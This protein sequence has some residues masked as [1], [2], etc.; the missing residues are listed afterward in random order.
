MDI[1][2]DASTLISFSQSCLIEILHRLQKQSNWRFLVT[3]TVYNEIITNPMKIKRFELNAIRLSR[4]IDQGWLAFIEPTSAETA[5]TEEISRHANQT[6]FANKQPLSLVHAGEAEALALC[7]SR[8]IPILAM[9]ERTTRM[10]IEGP[11]Q[12]RE[13]LAERTNNQIETNETSL[14][15]FRRNFSDLTIVRSVEL[16]GLAYERKLF[17]PTLS[18]NHQSLEAGLFALK[19]SGCAVSETELNEFLQ[20]HL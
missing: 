11:N 9:D 8:K 10:L 4:A 18:Q 3:R 20:K 7:Q 19:F 2:F 6:F 12:L 13:I 14:D 5:K 15:A 17:E 16:L 1:V